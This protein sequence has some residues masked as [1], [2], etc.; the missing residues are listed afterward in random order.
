M[1][2][3]VPGQCRLTQRGP[4]GAAGAVGAPGGVS[5]PGGPV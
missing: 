5:A 4:A 2:R 1:A 3:P